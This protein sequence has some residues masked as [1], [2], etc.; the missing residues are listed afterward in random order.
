MR[1]S[2]LLLILGESKEQREA[3]NQSH[4]AQAQA[5]LRSATRGLP[6]SILNA[7]WQIYAGWNPSWGKGRVLGSRGVQN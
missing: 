1:T 6:G 2:P 7:V 3:R 4:K 5:G